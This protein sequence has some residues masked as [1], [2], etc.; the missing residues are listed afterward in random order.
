MRAET[1]DILPGFRFDLGSEGFL[2]G[3]CGARQQEVL[4]DQQAEFVCRLVEVVA[5]EKSS[6]PHAN[7]VHVGVGRLL[8]PLTHALLRDAAREG[9]VGY[10]VDALDGDGPIV[11]DDPERGARF[12]R[13][14]VEPY[15]AETDP[16]L[17]GIKQF[18]AVPEL[19]GEVDER[20]VAVTPW[21]PERDIADAEGQL[22]F[23]SGDVGIHGCPCRAHTHL[24][25]L[26]TRAVE[27]DLHR[28]HAVGSL[29]QG[30]DGD[31]IESRSAPGLESDRSPDARGGRVEAPVPA[32]AAGHLAQCVVGMMVDVGP[33]AELEASA[34]RFGNGGGEPHLEP[35]DA[36]AEPVG[37]GHPVA[38]MLVLREQH[39]FPVE[40]DR[41]DRVQPL[42]VEVAAFIALVV[43]PHELGAVDPGRA[44]DPLLRALVQADVRVLDEARSEQVGMHHARHLGRY[45]A[46]RD[47]T[48]GNRAAFRRDGPGVVN[49]PPAKLCRH[50]HT[51][52]SA[53][54]A[55]SSIPASQYALA[56]GVRFCV[57]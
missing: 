11:D 15:G 18:V 3:V 30:R 44:A 51:M 49:R 4:P 48:V 52:T 20:L 26:V 54:S 43:A 7:E 8:Q 2:L 27:T 42:E 40:Q 23:P 31:R 16:A 24:H 25:R 47:D 32:V 29:H 55:P 36:G 50:A 41:G 21:P 37:D 46:R 5:L 10:P 57:S 45:P 9:I 28:H 13:L 34:I 1:R 12:V 35:V 17:V 38:A 19:D 53:A 6:T 33:I 22:G 14:R 56:F 39:G